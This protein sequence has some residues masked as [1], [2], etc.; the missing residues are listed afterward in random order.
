MLA[1]PLTT[2]VVVSTTVPLLLGSEMSVALETSTAGVVAVAVASVAVASS[3]AT[4]TS[5]A[6]ATKTESCNYE[7]TS[8]VYSKKYGLY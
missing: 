3:A 8:L 7:S 1:E 6:N 2:G 4:H 5:A